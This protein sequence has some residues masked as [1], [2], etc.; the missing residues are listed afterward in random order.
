[1]MDVLFRS[2]PVRAGLVWLLIMAP[3]CVLFWLQWRSLDGFEAASAQ[4]LKQG[5]RALGEQVAARIQRD[6]K[7]PT[8]NVLERVDHNDVREL[9][10]DTI[11]ARLTDLKRH[12]PLLETFFLWSN[13]A[14]GHAR[15]VRFFTTD[16]HA[17]A[18][19][20]AVNRF[21]ADPALSRLV[22][23]RS[24]EFASIHANFAL[25]QIT[26]ESRTYEVVYHLLYALPERRELQ[27][28]LG[29]MVDS[30]WLRDAYFRAIVGSEEVAQRQLVGF[31]PLLVSI[32]DDRGEEVFRSG[33]S[34]LGEFEDEIR[35]PYLFYDVDIVESLAP[36]R[37]TLRYWH[38]RTAFEAGS[39]ATIVRGQTNRQRL[40]WIIVGFVAAAGVALSARAA[41]REVR[42][43]EMKSD[44]VASVSHE[45][46]TP[47]AKIQ[48]FADTL[49]S[50]RVRSPQ[51][52]QE[53]AEIIS[54]QA[55]KLSVQI[56]RILDFGRI[57]AGR[58]RY[59]MQE[60]DVRAV[61]S[62]ALA[63]FEHQLSQND[64]DVELDVPEVEVPLNGNAEKLQQVFENLI[65]NAVK[66]SETTHFLH[67]KLRPVNGHVRVDFTDRGIG[68]PKG[69]QRRIFRKFYRG[70]QPRSKPVTG[71]GLGL[72]IV[73]HIVRAH[74]GRV[75][76]N[77][78]P[79][80]GSTFAVILP[81]CSEA[82][83]GRAS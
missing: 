20:A 9:R 7:S 47:L 74:G 16:G 58:G 73:D 71:S 25:A 8:F 57:E 81:A 18:P 77:S 36:F 80:Q 12:E 38:V 52:L 79:G 29:F 10:L 31:S 43:A 55:T 50:G 42:L 21:A 28:F 59:E 45:L 61:L 54:S 6:F 11:A 19:A 49:K 67:V 33:R 15:D 39:I 14:P 82:D 35:F 68:I 75:T 27:S 3:L 40:L 17:G 64:F 34:L 56:A 30:A 26:Y 69:D 2:R 23:D 65:T 37:P 83:R 32:V 13:V 72:A 78:A 5:S 76:V 46:K 22:L 70:P 53:Y 62:S 63:S 48:L 1:M 66:Y 60:I 44:F 51:K 41:I 24:R 4:V